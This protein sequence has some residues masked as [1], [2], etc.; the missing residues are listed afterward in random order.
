MAIFTGYVTTTGQ[1]QQ[2]ITGPDGNIWMVTQDGHITVFNVTTLTTTKYTVSGATVLFQ[3]CTDGTYLY[4]SDISPSGPPYNLV[5]RVTTAGVSSVFFSVGSFTNGGSL[6]F[7]G[8]NLWFTT[9]AHFYELNTAGSVLNTYGAPGNFGGGLINDGTYWWSSPSSGGASGIDRTP[10]S[11]P[12]TW[13]TVAMSSPISYSATYAGGLIWQGNLADPVCEIIA[14][15][16]PS[17]ANTVTLS[18]IAHCNVT[19]SAFDGVNF[20]IATQLFS[21]GGIPGIWQTTPGN[22]TVGTLYTTDSLGNSIGPTAILFETA[23]NS[24]WAA[25]HNLMWTMAVPTS[26]QLT[27]LT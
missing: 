8:T 1:P 20:W 14:V 13:T 10:M 2:M 26:N 7:D 6:F 27:L 19:A 11:G 5:Y 16:P 17:T 12:G 18:G 4:V 23:T 15:T 22:P 3:I 21:A 24:I 25:A 9:S